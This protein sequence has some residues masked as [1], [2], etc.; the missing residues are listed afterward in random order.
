MNTIWKNTFRAGEKW[1]GLIGRHKLLRFT[2]MEAGANLA[3]LLYNRL[4][5]NEKYNMPDT[6]KAQHT[7][8]LTAGNA[9]FSDKGRVLASIVE[10]SIGWHDT[11]GG[12][13]TRE[14]TD[15]KYGKTDYQTLRNDWLRNGYD[16]FMMELECNGLGPRDFVPPV[17]LFSKIRCDKDG[18][19]HADPENCPKGATVTLRTEM[20][21]LLVL[22]NTPNPLD[23]RKDYP[24]V[25]VKMEVL[26]AAP[27]DSLDP[28]MNSM[29]EVRRAYENTWDYYTLLG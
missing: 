21:V 19:M 25:P 20:D 6:L 23:P 10:D 22:S 17:N 9:L 1:S 24:A 2:A 4:E 14:S 28:C 18:H 8:H 15:Q 13:T 3:L 16:N 26:P 7:A 11:I 12:I 5:L 29:P 27:E